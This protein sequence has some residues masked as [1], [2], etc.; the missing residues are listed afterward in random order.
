MNDEF[1]DPLF[2]NL[3]ISHSRDGNGR[4]GSTY[5]YTTC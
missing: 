1:I 3:A 2:V 5:S 4:L